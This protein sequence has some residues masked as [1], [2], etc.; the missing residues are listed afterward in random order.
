MTQAVIDIAYF[1]LHDLFQWMMYFFSLSFFLTP[2]YNKY[3]MV[4]VITCI[5]FAPPIYKI[6]TSDNYSFFFLVF[7]LLAVALTGFEEKKILCVAAVG[8]QQLTIT[9]LSI[10]STTVI[11]EI[12][13]YY[14]T[15]LPVYTTVTVL[16]T[17][18]LDVLLFVVLEFAAL[19]WN[20]AL[21]K[22]NTKSMGFFLLLP[23][24]QSLFLV[25]CIYRAKEE[26]NIY[27][28]TNPYLIAAIV[29][30]V[31]S[32]ILV[33]LALR[34][35]SH[36]QDMRFRMEQIEQEMS[37]Q[38][39]YYEKL[40]EQYTIIREYRHDIRNLVSTVTALQQESKGGAVGEEL[41]TEMNE[42][43]N[44][45]DIPIFCGNPLINTVIW[46][47]SCEAEKAGVEFAADISIGDDMNIEKTELCSVFVNLLDNAIEEAALHKGCVS[48]SSQFKSGVLFIEATN[49]TD[50]VIS[51]K[52]K[53]RTSKSGNHGL[54]TEIIKKIAEKYNGTYVLTADGKIAKSTVSLCAL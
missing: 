4:L 26:M 19:I 47:K 9:V 51:D 40:S 42:R 35:N 49:T 33:Y 22:K 53:V 21:K 46:Q 50:K 36:L 15:E 34:D 13:G 25:A 39:K 52:S 29:F 12:L 43:A 37:M 28:L 18:I 2:K 10:V 45:L 31:L 5:G 8:V 32:D 44:K 17:V 14:P 1:V 11:H 6:I 3:L 41:I 7:L 38:T 16:Y 27:L 20:K 54:G 24:G 48:V 30:S 23:L